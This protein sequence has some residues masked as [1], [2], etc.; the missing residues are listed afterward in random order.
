MNEIP[1]RSYVE[2]VQHSMHCSID[3]VICLVRDV[4]Q[5]RVI[6]RPCAGGY[7]A[8]IWDLD[9]PPNERR[10]V[11]KSSAL[12]DSYAEGV[13]YGTEVVCAHVEGWVPSVEQGST[14]PVELP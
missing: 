1:N 2:A 12:L 10:L 5:Y 7:R 9:G 8:M 14:V 11:F 4:Y 13:W 6:S 3:G